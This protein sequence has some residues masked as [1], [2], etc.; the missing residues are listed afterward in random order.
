MTSTA[1]LHLLKE[2]AERER[3]R[4]RAEYQ[5]ALEHAR[6][7][8]GQL[9]QLS[10]YRVDYAQRWTR[11]FQQG[12]TA[13]MLHVVQDFG[14]KLDGVIVQQQHTVAHQDAM[15]EHA[16]QALV[17]RELRVATIQKLLERQR[18][19]QSRQQSRREQREMD[20]FAQRVATTRHRDTVEAN[21]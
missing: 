5:G 7:A 14:R 2:V 19:E 8:Q 9:S 20:E 1:T 21:P 11:H 17:Q 18:L 10:D 6:R 16:R 4:A 15:V 3:D 13:H 12:S